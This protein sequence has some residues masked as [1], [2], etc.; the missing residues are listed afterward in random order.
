MA[1]VLEGYGTNYGVRESG[2]VVTWF[3]NNARDDCGALKWAEVAFIASGRVSV[4]LADVLAPALT[5]WEV[6]HAEGYD[7]LKAWFAGV[8]P[9]V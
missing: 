9:L 7:G 3:V 8:R 6:A 1:E 4:D 5:P 2:Q